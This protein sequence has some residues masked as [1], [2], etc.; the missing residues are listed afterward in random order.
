MRPESAAG[1]RDIGGHSRGLW[2]PAGELFATDDDAVAAD[3]IDAAA[4]A[5]RP[6]PALL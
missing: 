5:E 6:Q 3:A 4:M 1:G 2:C